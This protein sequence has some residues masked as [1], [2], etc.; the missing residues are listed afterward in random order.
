MSK[1]KSAK[2]SSSVFYKVMNN[3]TH[4]YHHYILKHFVF[5]NVLKMSLINIYD[6]RTSSFHWN[7]TFPLFLQL[8]SSFS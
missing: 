1:H 6:F 8:R 5:T 4:K 3:P 2:I 7:F